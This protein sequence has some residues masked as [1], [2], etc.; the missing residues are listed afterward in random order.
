MSSR[1]WLA[2]GFTIA[3][4][5]FGGWR[6]AVP[7]SEGKT[8]GEAVTNLV[9]KITSASFAAAEVSLQAQRSATGS[10]AGAVLQ[11]PVTLV[12][13]DAVSY[14]IEYERDPLLQHVVGPD[15]VVTP[16]GC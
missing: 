8:T 11:P 9:D 16:G 2:V 1:L 6:L 3:T 15:G 4:V 5:A 13:A 12:R 10:Y 14:C 7:S